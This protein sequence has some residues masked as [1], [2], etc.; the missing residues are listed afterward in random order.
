MRQKGFAVEY[1]IMIAGAIFLAVMVILTLVNIASS[2]PKSFA[3]D[4]FNV[5]CTKLPQE[6]C[7]ATPI[8][9]A[10]TPIYCTFDTAA[11]KCKWLAT[12]CNNGIDDDKDNFT[13]LADN[14]CT[15]PSDDTE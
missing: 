15:A 8:D 10:G 6:S 11:N 12:Q 9:A 14:G 3:A 5:F 7:A 13:D 4:A 1:L 2:A